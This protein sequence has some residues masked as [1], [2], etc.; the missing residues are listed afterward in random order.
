MGADGNDARV[1]EAGPDWIDGQLDA[2]RQGVH[3]SLAWR[4]LDCDASVRGAGRLGRRERD[5]GLISEP[6]GNSVA[7]T[8]TGLAF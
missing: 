3:V 7:S 2:P 1:P 4:F 8:E 6:G 5:K